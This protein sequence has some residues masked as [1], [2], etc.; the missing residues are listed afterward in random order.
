MVPRTHRS[1]SRA[2]GA[3]RPRRWLHLAI[4]T[5]FVHVGAFA[6]AQFD[7]SLGTIEARLDGEPRT[8]TTYAYPES[9]E[10]GIPA[11][12]NYVPFPGGYVEGSIEGYPEGATRDSVEGLLDISFELDALPSDC[13]CTFE[14]PFHVMYFAED[15]IFGTVYASSQGGS[16]RITFE[17]FEVDEDDVVTA[18]G[19]MEAELGFMPGENGV[20]EDADW[21]A[22]MRLEG[23]FST[24]ILPDPHISIE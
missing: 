3:S 6:F 12:A 13:P 11:S 20:D 15:D 18:E 19:T 24:R 7:G 9:A 21:P 2:A 8:W 10:E 4:V 5:M 23:T 1:Q 22:S 17:R 16:V 14:D